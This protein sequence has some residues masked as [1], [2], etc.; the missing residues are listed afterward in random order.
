MFA[1]NFSN[2]I[3]ANWKPRHEVDDKSYFSLCLG[4]F[5]ANF[6]LSGLVKISP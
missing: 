2:E 6:V 1:K 4:D 3:F 5:E